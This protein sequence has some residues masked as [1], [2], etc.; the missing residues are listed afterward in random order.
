MAENITSEAIL[1]ALGLTN[2]EANTNEF[3]LSGVVPASISSTEIKKT[4][5]ILGITPE[6][7]SQEFSTVEFDFEKLKD[8]FNT[9]C[10]D[11]NDPLA[12]GVSSRAL[13]FCSKILFEYGPYIRTER[14]T[15]GDKAIRFRFP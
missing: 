1:G 13:E 10:K 7:F 6:H 8:Q 4:V 5:T 11:F 2:T 12:D 9:Y 14:K 15:K 3:Q